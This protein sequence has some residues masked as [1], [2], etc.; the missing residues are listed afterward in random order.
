[1]K[2]SLQK[3][4]WEEDRKWSAVGKV[5]DKVNGCGGYAFVHLRIDSDEGSS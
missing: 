3:V 1:M 2:A 4:G 5:Q